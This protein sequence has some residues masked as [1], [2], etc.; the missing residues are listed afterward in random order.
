MSVSARER[1]GRL[2]AARAIKPR[3]LSEAK[4]DPTAVPS[5]GAPPTSWC[6]AARKRGAWTFEQSQSAGTSQS[7]GSLATMPKRQ[8]SDATVA[9]HISGSLAQKWLSHPRRP[10]SRLQL[11]RGAGGAVANSTLVSFGNTPGAWSRRGRAACPE[12]MVADSHTCLCRP[13]PTP[14]SADDFPGILSLRVAG[15]CKAG[16]ARGYVSCYRSRNTGG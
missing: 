15:S 13:S 4:G 8:T 10:I 12:A 16:S 7:I 3:G 2:R 6:A 1:P 14:V 9:S 11:R 5:A